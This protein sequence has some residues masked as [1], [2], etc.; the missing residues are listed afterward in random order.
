MGQGIREHFALRLVP[1][2]RCLWGGGE[3]VLLAQKV[4]ESLFRAGGERKRDQSLTQV[5]QGALSD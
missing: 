3:S 2:D 4:G 5:G 1:G